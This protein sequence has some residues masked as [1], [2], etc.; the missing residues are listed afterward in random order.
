MKVPPNTHEYCSRT[1]PQKISCQNDTRLYDKGTKR[2]AAP[3]SKCAGLKP[4]FIRAAGASHPSDR[5]WVAYCGENSQG[6]DSGTRFFAHVGVVTP[7]CN[8]MF[9][10]VPGGCDAS[11]SGFDHYLAAFCRRVLDSMPPLRT[12]VLRGE[13]AVCGQPNRWLNPFYWLPVRGRPRRPARVG[14]SRF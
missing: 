9:A 10:V 2:A 7:N 11:G 1:N 8:A 14:S 13:C 3:P 5:P 4:G 6:H 12:I